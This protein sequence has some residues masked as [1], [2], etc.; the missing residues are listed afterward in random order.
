M[1]PIKRQNNTEE[2]NAGQQSR[3]GF[4]KVAL[5]VILGAALLAGLYFL[6][7]KIYLDY[8]L[9]RDVRSSR[10]YE[11][12]LREGKPEILQDLLVR[13][14]KN[15]VNDQ[16]TKSAV[17]FIA[18]R[19]FDNGGNIYE[20]YDY[21]NNHPELS[22]L[23]EA[24]K[25]YPEY[26]DFIK[27]KT[28]PPVFTNESMYAL[29]AY[30]EILDK[31]GYADTATLSTAANQY[32]K[33]AY[34]PKKL[35]EEN[36]ELRPVKGEENLQ[37]N[38]DKAKLFLEKAQKDVSAIIDGTFDTSIMLPQDILVGLNQ[39]ASALRILEVIGNPFP[40]QK[41]AM[42]IFEFNRKFSTEIVTELRMFTH[43]LDASTFVLLSPTSTAQLEISLAP[44]YG[45][46]TKV[47][48]LRENSVLDKLIK[49]K[50]RRQAYS[51]VNG[52]RI[53][54]PNYDIY[55][56][57]NMVTLAKASPKLKTWLMSNGWKEE[58]FK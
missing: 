24:E 23:K 13:D 12:S 26:F 57:W 55:G 30:F 4:F 53:L 45:Y 33:L 2:S 58:D 43:L 50:D 36:P 38:V 49:S 17:Y 52:K 21:I 41:S 54:V 51:V 47:N 37:K 44:I 28:A 10:A 18:H 56:K 46:D 34:F 5:F 16:Y 6:G 1:P 48:K 15:G 3:Q 22:F 8:I 7:N 27:Q 14:I 31:H 20:I 9:P 32:A 29:L 42:E 11:A 39:Y 19:Y 40:S 35:G 25:I